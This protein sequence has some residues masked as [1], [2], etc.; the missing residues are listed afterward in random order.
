MG[1]QLQL[2]LHRELIL[3]PA[4]TYASSQPSDPATTPGADHHVRFC[5]AGKGGGSVIGVTVTRNVCAARWWHDV[6]LR[7]DFAISHP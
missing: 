7:W 2:Q 5:V 1:I 3:Y 4:A 6:V